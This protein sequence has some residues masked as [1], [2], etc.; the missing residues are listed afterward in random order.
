MG[1]LDVDFSENFEL[2]FNDIFSLQRPIDFP[3]YTYKQENIINDAERLAGVKMISDSKGRLRPDHADLI[4]II[5]DKF[6]GAQWKEII[7]SAKPYVS[8]ASNGNEIYF[9]IMTKLDFTTT[10]NR[11]DVV[12]RIICTK[13]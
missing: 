10:Y 6:I 7:W 4:R 2:G 13:K 5:M 12:C 3:N 1:L 11:S 8:I 9:T